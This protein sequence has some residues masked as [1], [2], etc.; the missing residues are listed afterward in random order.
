MRSILAMSEACLR[1]FSEEV[2]SME[3]E[4]KVAAK[5]KPSRSTDGISPG[6]YPGFSKGGFKNVPH[7]LLIRSTALVL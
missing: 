7:L 3:E 2:D 6:P 4:G 1:G 5:L